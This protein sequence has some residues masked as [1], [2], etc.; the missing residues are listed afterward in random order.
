MDAEP[1]SDLP[2][3]QPA[4]G[5]GPGHHHPGVG[6]KLAALTD[7]GRTVLED[8]D[9]PV[10]DPFATFEGEQ[11]VV[12]LR[13]LMGQLGGAVRQVARAGTPEQQAAAAATLAEARKSIYLLLAEGPSAP[14]E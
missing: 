5:R 3:A 8:E 1:R 4:R 14:G 10:A 12:D 9:N 7:Q 6:R 2:D 11:P 13:D